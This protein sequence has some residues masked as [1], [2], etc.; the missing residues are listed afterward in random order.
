MATLR[1]PT[2]SPLRGKVLGQLLQRRGDASYCCDSRSPR[3]A[4][5][6]G[7]S[8]EGGAQVGGVVTAGFV[9]IGFF[10]YSL[11]TV[12]NLRSVCLNLGKD[13]AQP[14]LHLQLALLFLC[15]HYDPRPKH[16][17]GERTVL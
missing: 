3:R 15:F 14:Q 1:G 10:W 9:C 8:S 17:T 5:G 12:G 13:V 7:F 11:P 16:R 2:A 4:P 6:P